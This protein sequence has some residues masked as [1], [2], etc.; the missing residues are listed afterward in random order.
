MRTKRINRVILLITAFLLVVGLAGAPAAAIAQTSSPWQVNY[1]NNRTWAGAPIYTLFANTVAFNW[2]SDT[3]PVPGALAQN[4]SARLTTN[5]FFY[6]GNYNFQIVADDAFVLFIDGAVMFN[7]LGLNIPGKPINVM[8][9]LT[10]GNHFI[11]I[12][13]VQATGPAYL[14]MSWSFDKAINPPAPAPIPPLVG[15]LFPPPSSGPVTQFGDYSR[16]AQQQI[17]QSNCFQSNG[18]WDAPNVGSIQMEP[19]IVVW[20]NCTADQWQTRQLYPNQE[21][22]QAKC[23]KTEAGWFPG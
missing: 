17:H 8:A 6:A 16:C 13:Y 2:G 14:F 18:A 3:P 5:T 1:F 12:D 11:Q 10:Q 7:S 23:S 9:P 4:W 15:G 21:P 20:Q 19:Q 22:Q